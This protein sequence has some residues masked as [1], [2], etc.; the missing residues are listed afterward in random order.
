[1]KTGRDGNG[2]RPADSAICFLI[3]IALEIVGHL[4]ALSVTS[5]KGTTRLGEGRQLRMVGLKLCRA[6]EGS[7]FWR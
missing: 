2:D 5:G 6:T 4:D 7:R 1:M 3:R